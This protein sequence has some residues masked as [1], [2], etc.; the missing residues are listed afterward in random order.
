M[1]TTQTTRT[2]RMTAHAEPARAS[3][4][5]A[6]RVLAGGVG[7]SAAGAVV[8]LGYGA[9]AVALHGPMQAGDP[10]AADATPINAASFPIGLL[11]CA[12]VAIP[13]AVAIGRFASRPTRTFRHTAIVLTAV[14]LVAPIGA[15]HTD[16]ATRFLLA[17]GHVVAAAVVIP[18][19]IR[20]LRTTLD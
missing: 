20:A 7:A 16:V 12:V 1:T 2:R 17:G 18:L 10:G 13:L 6:R 9:L 4:P 11:F 3:R 19:I 14:S 5:R 8:L 15:T